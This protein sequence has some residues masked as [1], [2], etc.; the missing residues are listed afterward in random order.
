MFAR[1]LQARLHFNRRLQLRAHVGNLVDE[2]GDGDGL[3]Q[4]FVG[5]HHQICDLAR[6]LRPAIQPSREILG[7][8]DDGHAVMDRRNRSVGGRGQDGPGIDFGAIGRRP[9][10]H[11]SGKDHDAAVAWAYPVGL[12]LLATLLVGPVPLIKAGGGYQHAAM[13]HGGAE[14]GLFDCRFGT[15]IEQQG[16]SLGSLTQ[17]GVSPQRTSRARRSGRLL[18]ASWR[19]RKRPRGSAGSGQC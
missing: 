9:G 7:L 14:R 2:I 1:R 16:K 19:S 3:E 8:D 13:A 6:L 4:V 11:Q 5:R 17:E 15:G 18:P 12:R 10:F